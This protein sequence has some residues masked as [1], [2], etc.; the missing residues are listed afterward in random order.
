MKG[1][2]AVR[3]GTRA[4]RYQ[5]S[6]NRN[7]SSQSP[8]PPERGLS[9]GG[10]TGRGCRTAGRASDRHAANAG[11]IPRCGKGLFFHR[12]NFQCRLSYG[13]RTPP[14]SIACIHICAHVK[15]PVVG[16]RVRWIKEILNNTQHVPC[17]GQRDSVAAGFPRG[18]QLE[19]P[20]RERNSMGTI[21]L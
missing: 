5:L 7:Q 20:V 13:V 10:C 17:V 6:E 14:C 4:V 21:Q 12:G 3:R 9:F 18:K 16:V 8:V 1:A 19:F 15:D 2:R 11:S